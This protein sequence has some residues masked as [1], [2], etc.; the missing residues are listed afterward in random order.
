MRLKLGEELVAPKW[1]SLFARGS[2]GLLSG[3]TP[4]EIVK[5]H[6][7]RQGQEMDIS[8]VLGAREDTRYSIK[9]IS[10]PTDRQHRI[11]EGILHGT[12]D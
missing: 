1:R 2:G 7:T 10:H 6:I 4:G 8:Y 12:T 9:E 11:R 3:L 5:F